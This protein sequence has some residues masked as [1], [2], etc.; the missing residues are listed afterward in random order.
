MGRSLSAAGVENKPRG[1]DGESMDG[2][3]VGWVGFLGKE[4]GVRGSF[5]AFESAVAPL[6]RAGRVLRHVH[7]EYCC[8]EESPR[9][10]GAR[11]VLLEDLS[12]LGSYSVW[13]ADFEFH[14]QVSSLAGGLGEGQPLPAQSLHCPRLDDVVAGQRDHPPV[15][16]G[17]VHGAAAQGLFKTDVCRVDHVRPIPLEMRVRL[18]LEDEDDVG[19]DVVRGGVPFFGECDF[20]SLLPT[21][22]DDNV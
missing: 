16:G 20:G 19:R 11:E 22:F 2:G 12:R 8:L 15:D 9:A 1:M 17:N 10:L 3:G 13:E 21:P 7:L 4:S 18:V 5:F 14:D 6:L